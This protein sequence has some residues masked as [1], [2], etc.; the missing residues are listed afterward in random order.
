M[1]PAPLH[2]RRGA[3]GAG[4]AVAILW[5]GGLPAWIL[6]TL[7]VLVHELGHAVMAW[8]TGHPAIPKFDLQFGGGVTPIGE[9]SWLVSGL[10]LAAGA[11]L[12]VQAWP[13]RGWV[14]TG[15]IALVAVPLL[16][17]VTGLDSAAFTVAGFLGE[18][19]VAGVFLVRSL[20][21]MA[22]AHRLEGW[23]YAVCGWML[24]L[25]PLILSWQLATDPSARERY[26]E[27]KGG[28]DN[29]L[30]VVA[31]LLGGSVPGWGWA[32]IVVAL[33][34]LA[35]SGWAAWRLRGRAA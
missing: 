32:M 20:T 35:I 19:A 21:G 14:R 6:G 7:T 5:W 33:A 26:A 4:I 13:R 8:I 31:D 12:V 1:P 15:A 25:R 3:A 28:M 30:T 16:L 23:L 17:A 11:W 2:W 22:V 34:T 18:F 9:R 27:G 24:W 29:D 10:L